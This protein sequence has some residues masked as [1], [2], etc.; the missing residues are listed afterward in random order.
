MRRCFTLIELLVVIAIIAIL[1]AMLLPALNRAREAA[2]TTQCLSNLRQM[3]LFM[4]NYTSDNQDF[5]P[6]YFQTALATWNWAYGLNKEKYITANNIFFCPSSQ[7]LTQR[8]AKGAPESCTSQ[9]TWVYTYQYIEY[10]YSYNWVG[11]NN[12]RGGVSDSATMPGLPTLKTGQSKNPSSKFLF[13]DAR[14]TTVD[15]S[16]GKY[17]GTL[18]IRDG[19]TSYRMHPRHNNG[20][21]EGGDINITYIDGHSA[22]IPR[23]FSGPYETDIDTYWNPDK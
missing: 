23:Y 6:P 13:A 5:F 7:N 22:K 1:A 2:R 18:G 17:R 16:D 10:G 15:A 4:N 11:S 21:L 12:G 9:P 3:G 14:S 20:G 8:F 19:G